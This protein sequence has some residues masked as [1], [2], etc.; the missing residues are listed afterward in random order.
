MTS[1]TYAVYESSGLWDAPLAAW[2]GAADRLQR[3]KVHGVPVS[4]GIHTEATRDQVINAFR[5]QPGHWSY[6]RMDKGSEEIV[7]TFDRD[8]WAIERARAIL[9]SSTVIHTKSGHKQPKT[10]MLEAVATYL[11]TGRRVYKSGLHW[12]LRNTPPRA[13]AWRECEE[14]AQHHWSRILEHDPDALLE[15]TG[16]LNESMRAKVERG[17]VLNLVAGV[18]GMHQA[19]NLR[20]LP[21]QGTHGRQLIDNCLTNA[22]IL[23][24]GAV[25]LDRI[26]RFDHR[27]LGVLLGAPE[28]AG[29]NHAPTVRQS[30]PVLLKPIVEP[31]LEYDPLPFAA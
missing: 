18:P 3:S 2:H 29:H 1:G 26:P 21:T 19:W 14:R 10:Y 30:H 17:R 16:D 13:K 25:L 7:L 11:P 12:P 20:N 8:L 31:D 22:R 27:P 15:H 4:S 5:R 23:A 6:V 24:G 9:M 28:L